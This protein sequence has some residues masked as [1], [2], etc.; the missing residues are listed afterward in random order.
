[1]NEQSDF[2][3]NSTAASKAINFNSVARVLYLEGYNTKRG[4]GEQNWTLLT[5]QIYNDAQ[6]K[7]QA[8]V[9]K[10]VKV[11]DAIGTDDILEMEPMSSLFV[12]GAPSVGSNITIGTN[13][14]V[15]S[16]KQEIRDSAVSGDLNN[17]SVLYSKSLPMDSASSPSMTQQA[18]EANNLSTTL[19]STATVSV[20]SS[21]Y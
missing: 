8:L 20:P 19:F 5:E 21:G 15:R 13:D 14:L 18:L 11:S 1:L 4:V 3:Q 12:L 16:T 7:S 10:L 6:Q 2:L 9:C 17:V